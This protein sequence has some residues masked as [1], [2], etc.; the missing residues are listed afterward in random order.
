MIFLGCI[1]CDLTYCCRYNVVGLCTSLDGAFYGLLDRPF[2]TSVLTKKLRTMEFIHLGK[3]IQIVFVPLVRYC[4]QECWDEW[5]LELLE[6]VFGYCEDIFYHA[7]F[8]FLHE[9]RAQAPSYFGILRGQDEIVILFE[10]E[11]LL[12]FT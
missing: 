11:K 4:P 2:I 1:S 3:L 10:K 5:M 12:K 8:T 6:P 9:V 7:W